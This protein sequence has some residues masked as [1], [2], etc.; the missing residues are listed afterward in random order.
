MD[1]LLGQDFIIEFSTIRI[2][3][4]AE[5]GSVDHIDQHAAL[6]DAADLLLKFLEVDIRG[7]VFQIAEASISVPVSEFP[8]IFMQLL[9]ALAEDPH[10]I[11][12]DL[13]DQL[14]PMIGQLAVKSKGGHL[15]FALLDSDTLF[16][17]FFSSS[18]VR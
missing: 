14:Y 17:H 13:Q 5:Q 4:Q 16:P 9:R 11:P 18:H 3:F 15:F 1:E 2:P 12:V 6:H 10:H 8:C 7:K